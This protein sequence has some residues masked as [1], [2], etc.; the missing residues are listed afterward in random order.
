MDSIL[1]NLLKPASILSGIIIGAGVFSLP[2][3]FV[4]AG[5]ATSFFYL[6]FFGFIFILLYLFYADIILR[7]PG[8]HRFVGYARI[9]LGK[10]GFLASLLIGLAQLFFVLTI[11]LILAPSFSQMIFGGS[12]IPHLLIFWIIGSLTVFSDSRRLADLEFFIVAGIA[13]IMALIFFLGAGR[14][15]SST[16]GFGVP[17]LSKFLAVGPILFSLSGI[18]GVTEIV[19]YF[20]EAKI[21]VSFLR[22][23]LILGG[24]IPMI[25]YG[26]FVIGIIGLS[27]T[28]SQD[29]VSGL[30]GSLHPFLLGTIGVLG[31]L[32]LIS[33]Y[34]VVGENIRRIIR[35]D[36]S[37]PDMIGGIAAVFAPVIIFFMGFQNFIG[38]VSFVGMVFLPLESILIILMWLKMNKST[39]LPPILIKKW[40]QVFI[41][42]ILM[43]FL[44]ALIYAIM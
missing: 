13:L 35:Y 10:W 27:S 30:A 21:P 28:V 39:E 1:Q 11:Y 32:A 41:P 43:V 12:F 9:Y 38:A 19:S 33:S 40:M 4:T 37:F 25:A 17:D 24:A 29:S 44:T 3:I 20:R 36:L 26:A 16:A 2:Y 15:L 5:L 42:V 34:V 18:L 6:T 22:N 14:F 23:S 8:E 31:L 7:T